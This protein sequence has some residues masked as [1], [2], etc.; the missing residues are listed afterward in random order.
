MGLPVQFV[1]AV[2]L[3]LLETRVQMVDVMQRVGAFATVAPLRL[4][5]V[6]ETSQLNEESLVL[7]KS[8]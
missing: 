4:H 1:E 5:H 8:L 7:L 3:R 2:E 6:L